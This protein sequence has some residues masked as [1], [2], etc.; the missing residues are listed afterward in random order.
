MEINQYSSKKPGKKNK[1]DLS[2]GDDDLDLFNT[3]KMEKKPKL[4]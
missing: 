2:D 1:D 3:K 4:K